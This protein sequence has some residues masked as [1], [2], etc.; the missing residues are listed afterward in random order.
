[1]QKL[2]QLKFCAALCMLM[3]ISLIQIVFSVAFA[4][5]G[6]A[7]HE[8]RAQEILERSVTLHADQQELKEVLRQLEIQADVKF[9]YSQRLIKAERKVVMHVSGQRLSEA[10]KLLL[11]P[12][13]ITYQ[14]TS[15]RILLTMVKPQP[16]KLGEA[17]PKKKRRYCW[18]R[19][20]GKS[21]MKIMPV[22]RV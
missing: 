8:G 16:P 19:W 9:A 6:F 3:K 13:N 11:T 18:R 12:L 15:G 5:F 21:W 14:V 4:G 7:A 2:R 17:A 10:L 1:M 22:C 20:A